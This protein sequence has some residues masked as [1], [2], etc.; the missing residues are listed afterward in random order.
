MR[1]RLSYLEWLALLI[2]V[3]GIGL[4]ASFGPSS[5]TELPLPEVQKEFTGLVFLAFAIPAVAFI[6]LTVLILVPCSPIKRWRPAS[7]SIKLSLLS[8]AGAGMSGA[9]SITFAKVFTTAVFEEW[10]GENSTTGVELWITWL[11][12][13]V[14]IAC[15]PTQLWLLNW[16]L[17]S[18][19]ASFTVPLYTVM[20]IGANI[21]LGGLL[22]D[23]F[24]CLAENTLDLA[25]FIGAFIMVVIGVCLLSW[26]QE[27]AKRLA[28]GPPREGKA[29][30]TI[31][32]SIAGASTEHASLDMFRPRE[33]ERRNRMSH[34]DDPL[35]SQNRSNSAFGERSTALKDIIARQ[36]ADREA[37]VPPA[38][39]SPAQ[40]PPATADVAD[41]DVISPPMATK[42]RVLW[43]LHQRTQD[44]EQE[45]ARQQQDGAGITPA[46]SVASSSEGGLE[47][48]A[49]GEDPAAS[50]ASQGLFAR[51]FGRTA[52]S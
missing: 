1:E 49:G 37:Q 52:S 15:A 34:S 44:V 10:I 35:S 38:Q 39:E 30:F 18:G 47:L 43:W 50:G 19:K 42:K 28:A 11:A 25:V 33:V 8:A 16:A 46:E 32:V 14:I 48:E 2:A 9:F 7:N 13:G 36:A 5:E 3:T 29:P 26:G 51:M 21:V 12:L 4:C 24:T 45:S 41:V 40:E 27:R 6:L 23:E 22:F 20:I 17:G 31:F